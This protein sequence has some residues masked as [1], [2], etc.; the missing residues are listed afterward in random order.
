MKS[1]KLMDLDDAA[2]GVVLFE[3][4][5][6]GQGSVLLPAGTALT[7]AMLTSLRRRGID[8][9]RVV[10]DEI[11]A[12]ELAAERERVERRL[13]TLFRRCNT[14]PACKELLQQVTEYRLGRLE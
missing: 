3:D 8:T 13:A 5:R 1:F 2:A 6:D 11:P 14:E 12:A 4:V 7:D 10:N 9:I